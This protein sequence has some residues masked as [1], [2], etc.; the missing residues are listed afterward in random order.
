MRISPSPKESNRTYLVSQPARA[1]GLKFLIQDGR[2]RE[3]ARVRLYILDNDLHRRPF[4]LIEDLYV[5]PEHRGQGLAKKLLAR[6]LAEARRH[7]C[8][9]LIANSRTERPEVHGLY[10][11]LGFQ[12]HGIEFRLD[13]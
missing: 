5:A 6:A 9:K 4:G 2:G 7:R 13:L 3:L 8:Y 12:D 1:Q 11:G 10:R